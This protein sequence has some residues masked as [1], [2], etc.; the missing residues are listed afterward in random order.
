[1]LQVGLSPPRCPGAAAAAFPMAEPAAGEDTG[2]GREVLGSSPVTIVVTSEEADSWDID[3][4]S[5]RGCGHFVDWDKMPEPQGPAQIPRDV[6]GR[7]P[8]ELKRLAREGCWARSHAGRAGS[9]PGS[10]SGSP[11]ASSP[12]TRSSPAAGAGGAAAALQR[13][14]EAQCFESLSRLIA[15]NAPTPHTSTSPSWPTRPP[16]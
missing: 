9:T 3:T 10:S 8:K 12:P 16:A 13:E 1:M 14:D 15:S 6:L 7:P 5:C 2:T 4:S 11:A